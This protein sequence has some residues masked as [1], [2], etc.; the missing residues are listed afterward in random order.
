MKDKPAK[1]RL[2]EFTP[3]DSANESK[4]VEQVGVTV[5]A[6]QEMPQKQIKSKSCYIKHLVV[7]GIVKIGDLISDNGKFLKSEKLLQSQLSPIHFFKLMGIINSIPNDW[8]LIIKQSQQHVC[9]PSNDTIQI[10]IE[11]AA[12]DVLK[13]TS[14]ML[15]NEFKSKKQ[16]YYIYNCKLNVIHPSLKVF[17]AKLKAAC[18]IEQKIA[19]TNNKLERH[20]K[21]WKK[22]L[23]CFS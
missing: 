2:K 12:V 8:K 20:Y 10:H 5:L 17:I 21:K 4:L 16:V 13:A 1:F 3:A 15:Y 22:F 7:H 23:P 9:P 6:C 14:K 18:Q 11:S 19:A